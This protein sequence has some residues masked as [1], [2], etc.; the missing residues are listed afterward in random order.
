MRLRSRLDSLFKHFHEFRN[1]L[2]SGNSGKKLD[3]R[4]SGFAINPALGPEH[5]DTASDRH[6]ILTELLIKDAGAGLVGFLHAGGNARSLRIYDELPGISVARLD[7]GKHLLDRLRPLP[8]I[9]GDTTDHEGVLPEDRRPQQLAFHDEFSTGDLCCS[10]ERTLLNFLQRTDP[11]LLKRVTKK[12]INHL[13]WTGVREAQDLLRDS[14]QEFG[15]EVEAAGIDEN[16]PLARRQREDD[17]ALT[18][19]TFDLAARRLS[20]ANPGAPR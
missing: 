3:H 11:N 12:M 5:T 14:L 15:P 17:R 1:R 16:L 4:G 9:D 13:C 6:A 8:S 7:I 19:R 18:E 20:E 2:S 10:A